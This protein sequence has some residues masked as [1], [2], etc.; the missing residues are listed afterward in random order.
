MKRQAN[1][2]IMIIIAYVSFIA[3]AMP[4]GV[5]NI[6]WEYMEDTFQLSL[7]SLGPF[8]AIGTTGY[9]IAAFVSGRMVVRTGVGL[10]LF[11]GSV[12]TILGTLGFV[13][14]PVWS[15]LLVGSFV[16]GLGMGAIDAGLNTYVSAHYSASR[17]NWLHAFFGL[18]VT[19]GAP[20]VTFIIVTLGLSWRWGYAVVLV[21]E[22][23]VAVSFLL[24]LKWWK[25]EAQAN[26]DTSPD[27][28]P[29]SSPSLLDTLKMPLVLI[30]MMLFFVYTGLEEGVG[31]L[32]NS[33]FTEGRGIDQSTAS[34]WISFYWGSF[35]VGRMIIGVLADRINNIVIIRF[36]LLGA[37]LG[38]IL[39]WLNLADFFGFIALA[40][41]GFSLA[42][43]F[44]TMIAETPRRV[45]IRHAANSIGVQIG[46]AGIG[47]GV[48][49]GLGGVLA[50][51][52]G[53]EVIGP[54]LVVVAL[55]NF[56]LHEIILL[57][58]SQSEPQLL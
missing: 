27:G 39:L 16:H 28:N 40:L 4:V 7:D 29:G 43:V 35:T 6:A 42:P 45:G 56:M 37:L 22:I 21:L 44:P 13:L 49:P 32:S 25:I 31:Q 2:T 55:A 9:L 1:P 11:V 20:I 10:F 53:L 24:T 30:S 58:E 18:G 36:A 5:R 15:L 47:V 38:A 19:I 50:K 23:I 33:L 52:I 26:E 51:N 12:L 14:S 57:R 54:F 46:A 8:L 41:I 3:I 34:L 17:L 48:L